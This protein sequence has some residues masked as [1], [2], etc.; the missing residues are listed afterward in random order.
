MIEKLQLKFIF[1]TMLSIIIISCGIFWI[2]INSGIGSITGQ[3]DKIIEMIAGS[4]GE[5]PDI[6][7]KD[8]DKYHIF[9]EETKYTTR[10][11]TAIVDES[12]DF[13]SINTSKK[14][15]KGN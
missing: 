2:T 10:F 3:A 15:C 12:G 4:S 13:I 5:V 8:D 14:Y 6:K 7:T 1:I 11:F 9:N